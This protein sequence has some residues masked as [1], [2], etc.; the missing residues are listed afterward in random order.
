MGMR[1]RRGFGSLALTGWSLSAPRLERLERS[2]AL[3]ACSTLD[4]AQEAARRSEWQRDL[5]A[6]P[7]TAAPATT[8]EWN[9]AL[10]RGLQVLGRWFPDRFDHAEHP[11]FGD[12]FQARLLPGGFASWVEA[13]ADLGRRFQSFRLLKNHGLAMLGRSGEP[14]R[15]APE[16]VV[17]GM[18]LTF[19]FSSLREARPVNLLPFNAL[20]TKPRDRH[21]SL[22]LVKVVKVGARFHP[23]LVRLD[24]PLPGV[25]PPATLATQNHRLDPPEGSLMEVFLNEVTGGSR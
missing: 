11:H 25:D 24:G 20:D 8:A 9:A 10:Q 2:S 23:L 5:E 6:L 12:R 18:P 15:R 21:P 17:F 13:L 3:A 14:L 19:R 16:R 1:S 7:L 22:L 4:R